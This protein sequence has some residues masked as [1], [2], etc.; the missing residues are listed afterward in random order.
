MQG[1]IIPELVIESII[2]DGLQNVKNDKTIID[3]IFN[4][5]IRT[6]NDRKYGAA[7]IAKIKALVDKDIPVLYSYAQ[8]D[9]QSMS[10]TIMVGS[11]EEDKNRAHLSDHYEELEN[12]IV[13]PVKLQAL[14][15]VDN[16][17]VLS[18]DTLT[19][20]IIVDDTTNL[21]PVY[22]GMLYVD[23]VGNEF[24]IVTGI[25]NTPGDK[26]FYIQKGAEV[27][28]SNTDGFIKSS[29]DFERYELRGVTGNVRLVIGCHSKDA[30]TTK[31]MY[32]LLKY[33]LLSRKKDMIS[34][35]FY[36]STYSGSDFNRDS[37]YVGDQV[38]T[39]FLTTS[40]KVDDTWRSDQI[41]L[42]DNIEVV[43]TPVECP[44]DE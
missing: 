26:S 7:E 11:D 34:R 43:A 5:L 41:V 20:K 44:D 37:E 21:S 24:D 23:S 10:F 12:E 2:R 22:R 36:V 6:Y 17:Q 27:D 28:I 13:D 31:Y 33:F 38:Y 14:H 15:R 16:L 9:A 35:S 42:I 1:F 40:G 3:S 18:Y 32:I 29:L 4:Q 39:R 25:N 19:G 8:V 30:L